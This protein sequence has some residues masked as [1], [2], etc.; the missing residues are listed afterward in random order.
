MSL[1]EIYCI[2]L[3]TYGGYKFDQ[4]LGT[5]EISIQ[6]NDQKV[7]TQRHTLLCARYFYI[8]K[9]FITFCF[10][11]LGVRHLYQLP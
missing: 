4:L 1:V 5:V 10:T 3:H 2:P 8:F 9:N 6:T 7:L 11:S